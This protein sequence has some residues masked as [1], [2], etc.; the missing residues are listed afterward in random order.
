[1]TK[2]KM[3][4]CKH[5]GQEISANA[6]T[7][8]QCGGKNKKTIFKKWWFWLIIVIIIAAV[9]SGG[10]NAT[11]DTDNDT[12][13]IT[14]TE[15]PNKNTDSPQTDNI[16]TEYKSALKKAESHSK[17]MYMSKAGI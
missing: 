3:I 15:T 7:C 11:T 9:A 10:N 16:P 2:N 12:S 13:P 4:H 8:P 17:T 6:K 14:N 5:C 1:M